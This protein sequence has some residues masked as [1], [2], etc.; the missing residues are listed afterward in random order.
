MNEKD[1]IAHLFRKFI[2]EECN[3]HEIE[4]LLKFL[5]EEPKFNPLPEDDK[6]RAR[7]APEELFKIQSRI[8]ARYANLRELTVKET[9]KPKQKVRLRKNYLFQITAVCCLTI[10]LFGSWWFFIK[11]QA[12][13]STELLHDQGV[14]LELQGEKRVLKEEDSLVITSKDEKVLGIQKGNYLDLTKIDA[15]LANEKR[16]LNLE[17]SYGKKFNLL[18]PDSTYVYLNA[19]SSITIPLVFDNYSR[20]IMLYGEAYFDVKHNA[21]KPF[22]VQT[23]TLQVQVLGTEF[24]VLSYKEDKEVKVA[25]LQGKVALKNQENKERLYL[26]PGELATY[27]KNGKHLKITTEDLSYY[28][29]WKEDKLMF[30]NMS[31][32]NIFKKLERQ[33]D[34]TIKIEDAKLVEKKFYVHFK[35]EPLV[36]ILEYFSKAYGLRY[37]YVNDKTIVI[38]SKLKT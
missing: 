38:T 26:A 20:D 9:Y 19:G 7:I 17:V 3:E 27:N 37:T 11:K 18:L 4:E 2:R 12:G 25:L 22:N 31:L 29:A 1:Y 28:T 8:E 5:Q 33:Y 35:A 30:K 16:T 15:A 32:T 13:Q 10:M 34:V 6:D 21:H 36:T 24:N 23:E 14:V